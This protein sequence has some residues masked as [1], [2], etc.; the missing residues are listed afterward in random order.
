M[1]LYHSLKKM[2]HC[3]N[4]FTLVLALVGGGCVSSC[5]EMGIKVHTWVS[6]FF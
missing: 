6:M 2:Y 5:N 1:L 4:F 3:L